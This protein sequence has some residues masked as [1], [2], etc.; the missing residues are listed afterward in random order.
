MVML[1]GACSGAGID[2]LDGVDGAEALLDISDE[3]AGANCE[4][5]GIAIAV[6]T[7]TNGDGVL[8]ADETTE[9]SYVCDGGDGIPGADGTQTLVRTTDEPDG[10]N[11]ANGGVRIDYGADDSADGVLDP[12]EID[13]TVYVCDGEDGADGLQ[14]LLDITDEPVG[15]N[16]ANG[17][18]RIDYGT[19]DDDDGVLDADEIDGTEYVCHGGNESPASLCDAAGL[20][21]ITKGGV[22]FCYT[23]DPGTC[24]NAHTVCEGLGNGYR[25]MCGDDWNTGRFGTGCGGADAYTAYDFVGEFFPAETAAGSWNVGMDSCVYQC[26][27]A[28]QCTSDCGS[29][30][31]YDL[32]GYIAVCAPQDYYTVADDPAFAQVC[33][34]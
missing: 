30:A 24:N 12:D 9:V 29:N 6:G 16:C 2:G 15:V 32:V 17:G 21:S 18:V 27:G 11:C 10:A 25:L 8:D 22:E 14:T 5:G 13:G 7:D 19:D 28:L 33:G 4:F 20:D 23:S 31:T 26:Q 34:N 1:M 3:P